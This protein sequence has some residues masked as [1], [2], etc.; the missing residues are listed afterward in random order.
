MC[1]GI[2]KIDSWTK[3]TQLKIAGKI[4][5]FKESQKSQNTP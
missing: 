4:Q 2:I 1:L 3:R 5:E